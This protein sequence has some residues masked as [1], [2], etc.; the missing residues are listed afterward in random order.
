MTDA[1]QQYGVQLAEPS[2]IASVQGDTHDYTIYMHHIHDTSHACMGPGIRY[3]HRLLLFLQVWLDGLIL[4]VEVGHVHHQVLDHKHVRQRSELADFGGVAVHLAEARQR[5]L[6]IDV[7]RARATDALSAI[8][9]RGDACVRVIVTKQ[10]HCVHLFQGN[11]CRIAG[12]RLSG[13]AHP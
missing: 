1:L 11:T 2:H 12:R 7:H 3:L 5:V 13:L 9:R 6:A 4:R 10:D 8:P